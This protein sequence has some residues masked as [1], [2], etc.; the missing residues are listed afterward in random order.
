MIDNISNTASRV[1]L[2]FA[3]FYFDYQDQQ[4][5]TPTMVLSSIL[6]QLLERLP[7]VPKS[8][9]DLFD[10]ISSK[11]DLPLHECER[12][13]L[14]I[15]RDHPGTYIII[16]ALD[17]C[18]D[19]KH[20]KLLLQTME[21]LSQQGNCRVLAAS[22]PHVHD[23]EVSFPNAMRLDIQAQ[24][25]DLRSYLYQQLQ[26]GGICPQIADDGF[27]QRLVDKLTQGSGGM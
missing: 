24:Q 11:G 9:H 12:L 13:L 18:E 22:R 1:D 19:A 17:E 5:Q 6:R 25:D 2:P 4:A 8:V 14:D 23:V 26:R 3:Y 16:D 27:V 10:S 7:E 15:V 21:R 20:R